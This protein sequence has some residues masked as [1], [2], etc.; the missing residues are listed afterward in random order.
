MYKRLGVALVVLGA[1]SAAPAAET[2]REVTR[3]ENGNVDVLARN[4]PLGRLLKQFAL[5]TRL[6]TSLI[7]KRVEQTTVD[8]AVHDVPLD[9]ALGATLRA[10][11][12]SFVVWGADPAD[13]RVVAFAGSATS[14]ERSKPA[15]DAAPAPLVSNNVDAAIAAA[16]AAGISPDDPDLQMIGTGAPERTLAP[17][18]D[19]DLTEILGPAPEQKKPDEGPK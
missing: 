15:A 7:D 6:D 19:P 3:L 5:L 18:D 12:V 17:E 13:L 10:S 16:I 2:R 4:T 11:G 1:A 14:T 8:V 9:V